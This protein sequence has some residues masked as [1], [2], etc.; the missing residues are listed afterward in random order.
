MAFLTHHHITIHY[1]WIDQKRAQNI[2]LIN[3][4][5]T[6]LSIWNEVVSLI[7]QDF[8]VLVFDKRGHGLS[9]TQPGPVG[10]DDYAGDV[11]FLMDSLGIT[12]ANVL[13]LSIGG[14]IVYSLASRY[15]HR[16]EKL[17]FSNTGAKLG[18]FPSWQDRIQQIEKGG[19]EAIS[20]TIVQR[21]LSPD[22]RTAHPAET[23]GCINMLERNSAMGYIQACAAISQ[24]DYNPIL[25]RIDHPSMFIGGSADQSTPPK[26]V[27]ENAKNIGAARVEIL[28]GVGHLPCIEAP[29]KMAQL[30]LEF[31]ATPEPE[32]LYE[33]GMKT[34][35]AVLGDE[36]VDQAE[37]HKTGF[38]L[39]FQEYIVRS[40]WGSIWSRPHL[41][42]RER[43]MITIALLA[44]LGHEEELKMHIKAT[45]HTGASEN[46]V[47]EVLLHTGVYAGVPSTN[48]AMKIAKSFFSNSTVDHED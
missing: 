22:Y 48:G 20:K 39:D 17:I 29:G 19:L 9:S 21:W 24:A 34:R 35:R 41:T 14:L 6:H 40:A 13:G 36:H 37:A 4:L 8:N 43:S 28:D 23:E 42:K 30:I 16:F 2:L 46:D 44:A 26:L 7:A 38:D 10:I 11:L 18:T 33:L 32:S 1:Q 45:K 5:G 12:K 47:K 25:G 31:C 27:C 15:P 3:S